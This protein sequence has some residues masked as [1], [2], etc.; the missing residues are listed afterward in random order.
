MLH[1]YA[2]HVSCIIHNVFVYTAIKI[3]T[4]KLNFSLALVSTILADYWASTYVCKCDYQLAYPIQLACRLVS[5]TIY[6]GTTY[7]RIYTPGWIRNTHSGPTIYHTYV[8]T[9][10]QDRLINMC[11][12][13]WLAKPQ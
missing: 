10:P 12:S 7:I 9:Y 13:T 8:C 11:K 3:G 6:L 1:P 5:H 4:Q 2:G